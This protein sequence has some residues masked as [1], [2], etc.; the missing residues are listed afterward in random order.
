MTVLG[1][2]VTTGS[3]FDWV[4]F[5]NVVEDEALEQTTQNIVVNA[6]GIQTKN[7]DDGKVSLDGMNDD[8]KVAPADV[9]AVLSKQAP[10][11]VVAD[12]ENVN[13]DIKNQ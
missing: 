8:G 11:T 6:Y 1:K 2:N 5:A 9:W 12:P 7:I 3:L 10:S 4:K 13:T